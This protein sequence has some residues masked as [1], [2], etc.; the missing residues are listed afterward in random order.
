MNDQCPILCPECAAR[1]RRKVDAVAFGRTVRVGF[2]PH[3]DVYAEATVD[4]RDGL[5]DAGPMIELRTMSM[6][7]EEFEQHQR[8]FM[9]A[10]QEVIARLTY[11][12]LDDDEPPT[13]H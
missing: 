13:K 11:R 4:A 7:L 8:E 10:N 5:A 3:Y 6:T 12:S 1:L 9:A 2:C